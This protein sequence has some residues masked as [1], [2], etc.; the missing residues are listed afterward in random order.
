MFIGSTN[1]AIVKDQHFPCFDVC[2]HFLSRLY[3]RYHFGNASSPCCY[4]E[5]KKSDKRS[6]VFFNLGLMVAIGGSSVPSSSTASKVG[7]LTGRSVG[8]VDGISLG[9]SLGVSLGALLGVS[10]GLSL[11][12]SLGDAE[13]MIVTIGL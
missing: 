6:R 10:L 5:L 4:G 9:A 2:T 7:D 12:T 11:G 13:G 8:K 3:F 1:N